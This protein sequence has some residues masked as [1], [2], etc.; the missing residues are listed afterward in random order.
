MT[1]EGRNSGVRK[2]AVARQR[3]GEHIPAATKI[4]DSRTVGRG[5]LYAIHVVLNTQYVARG[6]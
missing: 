5:V 4:R 6:N 1:P 2:T 3:H